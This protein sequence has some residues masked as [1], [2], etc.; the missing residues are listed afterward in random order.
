M[1]GSVSPPGDGTTGVTG[2]AD[3]LGTVGRWVGKLG[4]PPGPHPGQVAAPSM[5]VLHPAAAAQVTGD[6]VFDAMS[7]CFAAIRALESGERVKIEY[8]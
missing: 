8:L 3:V 5:V 4:S 7:V 2:P 1:L 6:E